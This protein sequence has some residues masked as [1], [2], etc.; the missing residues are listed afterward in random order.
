M[1][2][3]PTCFVISPIGR[4]ESDTRKRADDFFDL[5][6]QPAVEKFG[7]RIVRA[8]QL[9][10]PTLITED[11][12]RLVQESELCIADLT[13]H[14]PNVFYE[15]G[16]RHETGRPC[17]Q[18]IDESEKVPFDLAGI[19]TISY[20]LTDPRAIRRTIVEIQNFISEIERSD[21]SST[22]SGV[23]M[24]AIAST[25]T[26]IERRL[27]TIDAARPTPKWSTRRTLE[28][29]FQN[30]LKEMQDAMV[31]G[32]LAALV[33]LLPRLEGAMGFN[34]AVI[35]TA[36]VVAINGVQEGADTLRRVLDG[37]ARLEPTL[38]KAAISGLVQYFVARS[39]QSEGRQIVEAVVTKYLNKAGNDGEEW[40]DSDRAFL[41]NQLSILQH[42]AGDYLAGLASLEKTL[43]LNPDERAYWYNI[44]IIYERLGRTE[45]ACDAA[46]R[47]ISGIDRPDPDHLAHAVSVLS[48]NGRREEA[49]TALRKLEHEYPERAGMVAKSI[50]T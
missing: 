50:G 12:L 17:I 30:P 3:E 2:T 35:Q 5:I 18:M 29:L 16:R 1:P 49:A 43:E 9:A 27:A 44:S 19:R 40:D 10:G 20:R 14:N 37:D 39:E 42:G 13:G 7:F 28:S 41:Y 8:D 45:E 47:A 32:D 23:S 38:A 4:S 25:L 31:R 36:A 48:E 21:F 26:R 34:E 22:S 11:I 24:S 33:E 15:C 46:L 6:A